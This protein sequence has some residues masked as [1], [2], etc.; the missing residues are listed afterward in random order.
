MLSKP[1]LFLN[2]WL[3]CCYDDNKDRYIS[4]LNFTTQNMD[5][6]YVT[7]IISKSRQLGAK[8]NYVGMTGYSPLITA[9][10]DHNVIAIRA[11]LFDDCDINKGYD[12]ILLQYLIKRQKMI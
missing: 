7:M 12:H 5:T 8:I 2:Q 4:N 10:L 9:T 6:T 3:R 1:E 11:L